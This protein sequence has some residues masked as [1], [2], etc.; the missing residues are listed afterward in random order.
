ML[1]DSYGLCEPTSESRATARAARCGRMSRCTVGRRCG[2]SPGASIVRDH[3]D[4]SARRRREMMVAVA[5][6][7]TLSANPNEFTNVSLHRLRSS[8]DISSPAARSIFK[9]SS[10]SSA[11][12]WSL[13]AT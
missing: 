6:C 2:G 13:R 8:F 10:T 7:S 5:L 11:F 12:L 4:A 3:R 1:E 9:Y